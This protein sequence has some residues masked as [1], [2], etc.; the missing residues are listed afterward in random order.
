LDGVS[1]GFVGGNTSRVMR[2]KTND[3]ILPHNL[4][5]RLRR[6]DGEFKKQSRPLGGDFADD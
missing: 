2:G 1:I 5:V 4:H 3:G 6:A